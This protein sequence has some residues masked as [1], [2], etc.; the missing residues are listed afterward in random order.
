ME[1]ASA[2]PLATQWYQSEDPKPMATFPTTTAVDARYT[3]ESIFGI[4]PFRS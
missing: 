1:I 3:D 2:S 4:I